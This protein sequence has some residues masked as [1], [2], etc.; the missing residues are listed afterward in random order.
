MTDGLR[1]ALTTLTV[2]PLRPGRVDRRAAGQAMLLAPLVGLVLALVVTP[3]LVAGPR[4]LPPGGAAAVLTAALTIA[5]LALLTRGL[6][7]DGLAD[8]V[9]GLAS[10]LPAAEA[11][12]VMRRGDVGALG[13]AALVL[14]LLTQVA[15]LAT[16]PSTG[17]AVE[18]L[19][20]AVVTGRLAV[21]CACTPRTPA[22]DPTGLG[23][24]VAGT[25]PVALAGLSVVT[26]VTVAVGYQLLVGGGY[27]AVQAA[28][29]VL[30]GLGVALL[31]R[32]HTVR[33]LGGL[34]GDVL[35]ALVEM[36]T[37]V[38]LVIMAVDVPA[39]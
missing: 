9:D 18:A 37:T 32:R 29:A 39:R 6:H 30:G 31:L 27:L 8:T 33:R 1:L 2:L 4:V 17:Q 25:V 22:A 16:A 26:V 23:A 12:A 36:A 10:Y 14:V 5:L 28:A 34:T 20:I 24:T 7:L 38:V 11:R 21:V 3:V 13:A 19:L 15:A 35:G